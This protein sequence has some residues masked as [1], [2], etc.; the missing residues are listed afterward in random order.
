MDGLSKCICMHTIYIELHF[1]TLVLVYHH[2]CEDSATRWDYNKVLSPTYALY[3]NVILPLTLK[4]NAFQMHTYMHICVSVY[5]S[6]EL[7]F[8]VL[9]LVVGLC[10]VIH[11]GLDKKVLKP[12]HDVYLHAMSNEF[13]HARRLLELILH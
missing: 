8:H 7:H 12:T 5:H 1:H 9:N 10:K 3:F 4:P 6:F 2:L 11:R 13:V